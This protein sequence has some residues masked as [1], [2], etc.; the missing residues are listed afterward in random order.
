MEKYNDLIIQKVLKFRQMTDIRRVC[1]VKII[2]YPENIL[3]VK[4]DSSM[5]KKTK[6]KVL[7]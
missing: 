4:S 1:E 6:I 5:Q 7:L 2:L 3:K